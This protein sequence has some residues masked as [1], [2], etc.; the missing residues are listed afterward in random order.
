MIR[1]RSKT[2]YHPFDIIR[3]NVS[4][5]SHYR[6]D[7]GLIL[8]VLAVVYFSLRKITTHTRTII[9]V[10]IAGIC[11]HLLNT[12][13]VRKIYHLSAT[14]NGRDTIVLNC[15]TNRLSSQVDNIF[16]TFLPLGMNAIRLTS[17]YFNRPT[18]ECNATK[19][20]AIQTFLH[21]FDTTRIYCPADY[22][23]PEQQILSVNHITYHPSGNEKVLKIIKDSLSFFHLTRPDHRLSVLSFF[24]GEYR[25]RLWNNHVIPKTRET[26]R[27]EA[28]NH[29]GD[30][31][32]KWAHD[33]EPLSVVIFSTGHIGQNCNIYHANKPFDGIVAISLFTGIPI[34]PVFNAY[35]ITK[36]NKEHFRQIVST[37][38]FVKPCRETS[39]DM[40]VMKTKYK[41]AMAFLHDRLQQSY[42]HMSN[43][44]RRNHKLNDDMETEWKIDASEHCLTCSHG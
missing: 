22:T 32:S 16:F 36:D 20:V 17:V 4:S 7:Y 24:G 41:S 10:F 29:Y 13:Y 21:F 40:D 15:E 12:I 9:S 44:L 6:N 11:L 5:S 3:D 42:M 25:E 43:E 30:M 27:R 33:E 37:P 34:V 38:L 8:I 18:R 39:F 23:I 28:F 2:E 31:V 26:G 19:P 35:Y 14:S 1:I